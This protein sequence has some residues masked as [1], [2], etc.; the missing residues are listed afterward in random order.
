MFCQNCGHQLKENAKFCQNCG[1]KLVEER[2]ENIEVENNEKI[3]NEN[4][5]N[6]KKITKIIFIVLAIVIALLLIISGALENI[7]SEFIDLNREIENNATGA[8]S[9]SGWQSADDL[10]TTT[11]NTTSSS[12]SSFAWIE[13]PYMIEDDLGFKYIVGSIEN[14][15]EKT[16]S[17]VSVEFALYDSYGNQVGTTIDSIDHFE[18][19]NVWKFKAVVFENEA[20][21]F[22]FIQANKSY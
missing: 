19:G 21:Y 12:E 8:T 10:F 1:E 16:F 22:E 20:E 15:S 2:P 13:E 18:S 7:I 6:L 14:I 17:Y 3:I 5:N 11:P 4:T 9:S